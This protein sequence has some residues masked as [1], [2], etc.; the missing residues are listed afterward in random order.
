MN[1]VGKW[2]E[3]NQNH[4]DEVMGIGWEGRD[5]KR[6]GKRDG[7]VAGNSGGT[8]AA[9]SAAKAMGTLLANEWK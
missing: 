9:K 6:D 7:Q 5:A 8:N 4:A 1:L 3:R 2:W